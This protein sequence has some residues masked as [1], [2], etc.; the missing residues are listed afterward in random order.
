MI[1]S[2]V[3]TPVSNSSIWC[4]RIIGGNLSGARE[5]SGNFVLLGIGNTAHGWQ[6]HGRIMSSWNREIRYSLIA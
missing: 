3:C 2:G 1:K 5:Y 4:R 6:V